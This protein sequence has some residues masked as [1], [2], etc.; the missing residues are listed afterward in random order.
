MGDRLINKQLS[1]CMTKFSWLFQWSGFTLLAISLAQVP[2]FAFD[3]D[4]VSQMLAQV[5]PATSVNRPILRIGSQG[6]VVSELQAALKLLGYY[7]DTVDGLYQQNTAIAVSKF[8]QVSGVKPDGITGPDTWN[9]LFPGQSSA[10]TPPVTSS[11]KPVAASGASFVVPTTKTRHSPTTSTPN[12]PTA[13]TTKPSTVDLPVLRR[14]MRGSAVAQLQERLKSL[15]FFKDSV[16][17][18]FGEVTE[19]AV[20]T[21]QQNL[22]IPTDGIVGPSTWGVLLR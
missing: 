12:P 15:G 21:A 18:I 16:D 4:S 10:V 6:A 5:T 14:G 7:S 3:D 22:K 8:Q 13:T 9:R 11:T 1:C 20:K 2:A 17:G 19:V